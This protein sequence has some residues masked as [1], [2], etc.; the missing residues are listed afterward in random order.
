MENLDMA[1]KCKNDVSIE[2]TRKFKHLAY[3]LSFSSIDRLIL[4]LLGVSALTFFF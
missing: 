3:G 4:L 2:Y 1:I